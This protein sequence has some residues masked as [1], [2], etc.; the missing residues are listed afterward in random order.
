MQPFKRWTEIQQIA[1]VVVGGDGGGGGGG[2]G[3]PVGQSQICHELLGTR[4]TRRGQLAF[5]FYNSL[6]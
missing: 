5:N 3:E 6:Y 4:R 2:G 1:R